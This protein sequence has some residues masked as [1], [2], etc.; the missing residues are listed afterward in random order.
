MVDNSSC[1]LSYYTSTHASIWHR[2]R[3][4]APQR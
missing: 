3:D 1:H 4:M 2:Y